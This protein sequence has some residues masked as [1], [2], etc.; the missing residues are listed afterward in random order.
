MCK[1][2]LNVRVCE[3]ADEGLVIES[4]IGEGAE[5]YVLLSAISNGPL[6][7]TSKFLNCLSYKKVLK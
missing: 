7:L 5:K 3:F 2:I 1:P 4:N 6:T